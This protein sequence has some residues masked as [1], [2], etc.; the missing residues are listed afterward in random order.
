MIHRTGTVLQVVWS[1]SVTATILFQASPASAGELPQ[2]TE[3]DGT[4]M[5]QPGAIGAAGRLQPG[6]RPMS[7]LPG[8]MQ[9]VEVRGPAGL[10]VAFET[11]E[12]WSQPVGLPV[13][14]ALRVGLPYRLRLT[15]LTGEED[16]AVYPSLRVLARMATPPGMD[17]RFPVEVVI[18]RDDLERS[19]AGGHVTR[20]VYV[21]HE[22]DA[23]GVTPDR[24]FD[25]R[26][27]DDPLDVAATLGQPIAELKLGNRVPASG[28]GS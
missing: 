8:D 26:P 4:R 25:V 28:G 5:F 10:E 11:V 20:V 9:V 14:T 22:P 15:G 18:D 13:R 19:V 6:S 2:G 21:S 27:G 3:A 7:T 16:R 12:G 24:W 23:R 1:M 17:W